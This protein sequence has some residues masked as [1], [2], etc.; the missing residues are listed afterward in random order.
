MTLTE[1]ADTKWTKLLA[2][3][4]MML[5]PLMIAGFFAAWSFT[6]Q[7]VK[8]EL[9]A[10]QTKIATVQNVQDARAKDSEAFQTEVRSAVSDLKD[11]IAGVKTEVYN[12]R[13]DVGVIKRLVTEIRDD[14]KVATTGM[15]SNW[16]AMAALP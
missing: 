1:W 4:A 12:T 8:Q 5:T 7:D 14:A 9:G 13:I 10:A 6:T 3:S 15:P 16:Q 2:R 11:Q